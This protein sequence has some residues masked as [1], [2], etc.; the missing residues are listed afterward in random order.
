MG[1]L[2][3]AF[4]RKGGRKTVWGGRQ[5]SQN[6]DRDIKVTMKKLNKVKNLLTDEQYKEILAK[7]A[8]I[9]Q[10]AIIQEAPI[11]KAKYHTIKDGGGKTKRVKAGN[12]RRSIQ[13]FTFR[14]SN[15]VFAGPITSKRS[16]V[17]KVGSRKLSRRKRAFYW[18]FVYYGAYNK[19][20]NRFTDRA[21]AKSEG[22]IRA[23]LISQTKRYLPKRLRKLMD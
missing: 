19:A 6:I 13:V 23:V 5:M 2:T 20:P 7:G 1:R 18:K 17:K 22:Q 15:A 4:Y 14:N 8:D 3:E 16:K 9:A 12:L 10:E 11:G 21:K